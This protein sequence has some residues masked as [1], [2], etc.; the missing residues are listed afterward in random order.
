MFLLSALVVVVVLFFLNKKTR[1]GA[2]VDRLMMVTFPFQPVDSLLL[3]VQS[4]AGLFIN[5]VIVL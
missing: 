1:G 3:L 5:Y 4:S 2:T